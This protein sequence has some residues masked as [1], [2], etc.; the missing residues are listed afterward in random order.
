MRL[1]AGVYNVAGGKPI[2]MKRLAEVIVG[3]VPTCKSVVTASGQADVQEG[4]TADYSIENIWR[5]LGWRPRVSLEERLGPCV[6]AKA[7]WKP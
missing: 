5:D 6:R 4:A 1:N 2:T 7:L 3:C